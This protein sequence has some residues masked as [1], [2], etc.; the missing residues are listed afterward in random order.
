MRRPVVLA[1]ALTFFFALLA[2]FG[3]QATA[4]TDNGNG[5]NTCHYDVFT[6]ATQVRENPDTDSVI[7]KWKYWME[8]VTGPCQEVLD[9]ESGVWFTAVYCTCAT[10]GIGWIRS[11]ALVS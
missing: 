11:S 9:G 1:A 10:D 5:I 6:D 8:H 3:A 4:G 2:P 7:R